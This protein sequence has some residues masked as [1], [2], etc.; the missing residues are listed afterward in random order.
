M[1]HL[2]GSI[3]DNSLLSDEGKLLVVV[4]V[5]RHQLSFNRVVAYGLECPHSLSCK[6]IKKSNTTR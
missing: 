2:N 4:F 1:T 5:G 6:S 3:V